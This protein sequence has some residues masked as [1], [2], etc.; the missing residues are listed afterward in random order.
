MRT[1]QSKKAI[2][3]AKSWKSQFVN[4]FLGNHLDLYR[5][6]AQYRIGGAAF[7]WVFKRAVLVSLRYLLA[8]KLTS[9]EL[10]LLEDA[11]YPYCLLVA[12]AGPIS[13][14]FVRTQV[15]DCC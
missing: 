2:S 6:P 8:G 14:P 15:T 11:W 12:R 9:T 4:T 3:H 7:L 5:R 10:R 13:A 1:E